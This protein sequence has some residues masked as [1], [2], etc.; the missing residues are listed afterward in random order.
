MSDLV[1]RAAELIGVAIGQQVDEQTGPLRAELSSVRRDRDILRDSV[2]A[3]SEAEARA[4]GRWM[5]AQAERDAAR[6]E[7]A[8]VAAQRDAYLTRSVELATRVT[9]LEA[10]LAAVAPVETAEVDGFCVGDLVRFNH[11]TLPLLEV[12]HDETVGFAFGTV[13]CDSPHRRKSCSQLQHM[14]R[15]PVEVGDTVRVVEGRYEGLVGVVD[16]VIGEEA[17]VVIDPK[18][19]MGE[20]RWVM[21]PRLVAV[22]P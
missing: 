15:K 5:T 13:A 2:K 8:G 1:M 16:G 12:F 17:R 3:W 6:A 20:A 21:L 4:R 7:L 9:E 19:S 18:V 10:R 11:E 14:V 22:A